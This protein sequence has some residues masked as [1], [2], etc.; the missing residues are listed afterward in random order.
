MKWLLQFEVLPSPLNMAGSSSSSTASSGHLLPS[1]PNYE[2][3][4]MHDSYRKLLE[5]QKK[6]GELLLASES[7][8]T[9]IWKSLYLAQESGSVE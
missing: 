4:K 8:S 2:L 9:Q 3:K 1:M 7:L 6:V 5:E